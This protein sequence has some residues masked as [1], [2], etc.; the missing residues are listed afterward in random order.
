MELCKYFRI[1]VEIF[2]IILETRKGEKLFFILILTCYHFFIRAQI[3]H[4]TLQIL[5][6]RLYHS[7][8]PKITS[9]PFYNEGHLP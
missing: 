1:I 2:T 6:G 4:D 3:L 7:V 9:L 5:D 8:F